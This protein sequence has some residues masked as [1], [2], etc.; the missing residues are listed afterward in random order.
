[1]HDFAIS[2]NVPRPYVTSNIVIVICAIVTLI[3]ILIS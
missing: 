2:M 1:M 3:A